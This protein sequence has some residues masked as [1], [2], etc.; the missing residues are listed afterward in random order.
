MP[1]QQQQSLLVETLGVM[2]NVVGMMYL[3]AWLQMTGRLDKDSSR[4]LS[5]FVGTIALPALFFKALAE[6]NLFEADPI[7]VAALVLSKSVMVT[8]SVLGGWW[9]QMRTVDAPGL[10][11]LR[12]GMF[13]MLTTNGDELG[14]GI[15][16]VTAI[17][18]HMVPMLFV[19]ASIQKFFFLPIELVLLGV[20]KQLKAADA[21]GKKKDNTGV[22]RPPPNVMQILGKVIAHKVREPLVIA[23][24][25]GLAYNLVGPP[26]THNPL[27]SDEEID[28]YRPSLMGGA[29]LPSYVVS[30]TSSL[31]AAFSPVIF[32]LTGAASV[33]T[34]SALASYYV[35][36]M[37]ITLVLLK[38]V[39]L[40]ALLYACAGTLG[41]SIT[42][43]DFA[44][45]VG[46]F[47]AAGSSM[48]IC[49]DAG[50]NERQQL[51]MM[52]TL[53]LGKLVSFPL[54]L[55]ATPMLSMSS[56]DAARLL[57]TIDV[58]LQS[59]SIVLCVWFLVLCVLYAPHAKF[60][61]LLS[62]GKRGETVAL[63]VFQALLL[64][65]HRIFGGGCTSTG[66]CQS[67]HAVWPPPWGRATD[68]LHWATEAA[69]LCMMALHVAHLRSKRAAMEGN[70]GKVGA[71]TAAA[72]AEE[73][74]EAA[75][76][77]EHRSLLR[78]LFLPPSLSTMSSSSSQ[79]SSMGTSCSTPLLGASSSSNTV[80]AEARMA[81]RLS[82]HEISDETR[83]ER[84]ED[85][86]AT[87]Q[88]HHPPAATAAPSFPSSSSSST[89]TSFSRV[90]HESH[91]LLMV[92]APLAAGIALTVLTGLVANSSLL[93]ARQQLNLD[94]TLE[95][96]LAAL[97]FYGFVQLL[98]V[99]MGAPKNL[100]DEPTSNQSVSDHRQPAAKALTLL[101]RASTAPDRITATAS[102]RLPIT[103]PTSEELDTHNVSESYQ[104]FNQR[105]KLLLVINTVQHILSALFIACEPEKGQPHG[106]LAVLALLEVAFRSGRGM[107]LFALFGWS[108]ASHQ[109]QTIWTSICPAQAVSEVDQKHAKRDSEAV[110][111][112]TRMFS[113]GM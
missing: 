88:A 110:V 91:L 50:I 68:M 44:F 18:P 32:V 21:A 46:L 111:R 101:H 20:G 86:E 27:W 109:V 112:V 55:L 38:S 83:Y 78:Q 64:I 42:A 75:V 82:S 60:S 61:L 36:V 22:S 5:A 113:L 8:V 89:T 100:F 81:A 47:P 30:I 107:L 40:P 16:V 71:R 2:V 14:L 33:G 85:E 3:G 6:E 63:V 34:F 79:A 53:S 4:G 96:M 10:R 98:K 80:S 106:A 19:L 11:E 37:P 26:S 56:A 70:A 72:A 97:D 35:L 58:T 57:E 87:P 9:A 54:L 66:F 29:A 99:G 13:A 25:C 1:E 90:S 73:E 49:K 108:R 59:T 76:G 45:V 7:I 105:L 31:G 77:E 103:R 95:L 65:S 17:F 48:V 104:A 41:A 24:F 93:T 51:I 84:L 67:N 28:G 62:H 74:E 52:A 94:V 92:L 43:R 12:C 23:I 39:V 15:P 102:S 69:L